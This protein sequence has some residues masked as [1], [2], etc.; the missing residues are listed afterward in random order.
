MNSIESNKIEFKSKYTNKLI[1]EIVAFINADGGKIYIGIEDNGNVIGAKNIDETLRSIADI[2]T[3]QIEPAATD[4]VTPEIQVIDG[5]PVVVINIKK[6]IAP[7]YCIKKHGFSSIGC[8]IRI[9][10]SCREMSETQIHE[11]YK[12]RFFDDDLLVTAPSNLPKLSFLTLKNYYLEQGYKLNDNTFESN[13]KLINSDGKY[14]VMAELLSDDN[15]FSLIFVKFKGLNRA[16][17]SQRSDYGNKSIL[18]GLCQLMNRIQAE[19]ICKTDTS[20]RPRIDTY[21]YDY[22]CVNE[23]VVNAILHNDWSITEPQVSFYSNR[24]EILSH[25]GLPYGLTEDQFYMGF[26]KP[27]NKQLMKIFSQL[28]IVEHTGHGIPIIISKYGKEA[29]DIQSNYILV[30]IPFNE[31]V[32]QTTN[33]ANNST[34]IDINDIEKTILE[35]LIKNPTLNADKLSEMINKSKR[36]MERYLKSLQ[37]RGY[38]VRENLYQN[39]IWK[40]IK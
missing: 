17:I 7:I 36:T 13:L 4:I 19:N 8:P 28:N 5:Q 34:T 11:R 24:I 9:G 12:Q 23:A 20:V 29:F 37:E 3:T 35:E 2:I 30:T 26:S 10:S 32:M 16:S 1:R 31:E 15:R 33:I 14:N 40:V 22:D 25:G 21:L 18:F 39:S 27:R 6:G 38:I